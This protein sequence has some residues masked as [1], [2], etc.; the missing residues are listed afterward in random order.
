M[1]RIFALAL[2]LVLLTLAAC[3]GSGGEITVWRAVSPYYLDSGSAIE[4]ENV[5]VDI[6][7]SVIDAAVGAFNSEVTEPELIR[8]L[9]DGVEITGW[10]LDGTELRLSVSAEYV[11]LTGYWRTIADACMTL[12]FCAIDGVE[13]V[14]V[15]SG[16]TMLTAP[17]APDDIVLTDTSGAGE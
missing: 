14:S 11:S 2:T 5:S 8:A 17:M 12:T 13:R 3:G 16:D 1:K 6:S 15:Y 4:T 9:P 7:L 10:E